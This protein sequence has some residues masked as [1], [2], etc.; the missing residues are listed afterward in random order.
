MRLGLTG[1]VGLF[2]TGSDMILRCPKCGSTDVNLEC[3]PRRGGPE[4]G[5]IEFLARCESTETDCG[6]RFFVWYKTT[7]SSISRDL[8]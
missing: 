7:L 2:W 8:I 3:I 5:S 1:V 4:K 6:V